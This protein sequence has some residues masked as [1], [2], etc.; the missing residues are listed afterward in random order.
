MGFFKKESNVSKPTIKCPVCGQEHIVSVYNHDKLYL[1]GIPAI[2][3]SN[4]MEMWVECET[5]GLLYSPEQ[6]TVDWELLRQSDEYQRAREKSYDSITERKLA[7]LYALLHKSYVPMYSAHYYHEIGN[8]QKEQ[9]SINIITHAIQ[10]GTYQAVYRFNIG[11]FVA[12]RN[13]RGPFT[14]TPKV[15][16]VDLYRRTS[17]WDAALQQIEQLRTAEYVVTP[18]E[19]FEYLKVEERLIKKHNNDLR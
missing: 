10:E 13:H 15:L 14:L 8:K 18:Y 7:L 5:C 16:L 6:L 4:I 12:M 9:E 11:N 17:Q 3:I 2:P 19:L 1:D